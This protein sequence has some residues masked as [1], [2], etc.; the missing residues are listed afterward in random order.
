[1][2]LWMWGVAYVATGL[3]SFKCDKPYKYKYDNHTNEVIEPLKKQ[4][5]A[6]VVSCMYSK[7]Q[8]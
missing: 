4:S 5:T 6:V 1:M 8:H 3:F 2:W 7:W